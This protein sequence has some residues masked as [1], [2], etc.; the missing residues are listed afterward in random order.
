MGGRVLLVDDDPSM[1]E[2]LCLRLSK[3][4]FDVAWHTG[5]AEALARLLAEDFDV[6]V[7]DLQMEGMDG[8]ELCERIVANRPD[9]PVVVMTAHPGLS[10]AVG[11]IRARASDFLVKPF[12]IDALVASVQNATRERRARSGIAPAPVHA[13]PDEWSDLVGASPAMKELRDLLLRVAS[14]DASVVITGESGTGKELVARALH[15]RSTRARRPFVALNCAAVPES[16]L[17][18]ELFGHVKGAFTDARS[19]RQGLFEQA[20][21]GALL[22]DEVGDLHEHLQPKLLRALQ[23]RVIRPIGSGREIPFDVRILA[24]TNRDLRALVSTGRFRDDLYYRLSVIDV[25][26]PPLRERGDDVLLCAQHF[27]QRYAAAFDKKVTGISPEAAK[28][29]LGHAWPGNVRELQNT[30][31]R[32]VALTRHEQIIVD[33]LPQPLRKYTR[34]RTGLAPA[35]LASLDEVERFHITAV[36][37]ATGGNRT[38]AAEILGV[39]RRTLHRKE[40]RWR[41]ASVPVS[42]KGREKP[43]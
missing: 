11:A 9:V 29:L 37:T 6:V 36:M 20:Q 4:G 35:T 33:D 22:L 5:G 10:T 7:T 26:V 17:E 43:K 16:L 27:V 1:C 32:A 42:S 28:R 40:R 3:R 15:R 21:G 39:D 41:L 14:V 13:E 19:E 38:A 2:L 12:E 8:L 18:S 24:A 31:E 30:I 25:H 23:E 34:G